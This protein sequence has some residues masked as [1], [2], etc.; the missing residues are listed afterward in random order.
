MADI[1]VTDNLGNPVDNIKVNLSRPSSILKY[2]RSELF[3]F[4]VFPDF[5]KLK[6]TTLS[7]AAPKPIQFQAT[8]QH[9]CQLGKKEAEIDVTPKAGATVRVNASSGADLFDDDPFHAPAKVSDQTGYLSAGFTGG[10][11]LGVSGSDGDLTFGFDEKSSVTVEYWKAF[12]LGSDEPTLGS[13][14]VQNLSSFVIPA[15]ISDLAGLS[16]HDVATVSGTGSLKVSGGVTFSASP[17]PLASATLPFGAGQIAVKAGATAGLS[18][19]FTISGSYQIRVRR[20]DAGTIELSFFKEKGTTFKADLS[21]S[22]GVTAGEGDGDFIG[23]LLNAISTDPVGDKNRL[24]D[25]VAANAKAFRVAIKNG[26]DHSLQASLDLALSSATDDQAAF[27]YEIQPSQ[28]T[29][30]GSL[31]VNRALKGDLT[32][33]TALEDGGPGNVLAPGITMLSSVLKQTR[34][35][36]MTLKVN[37]LGIVNLISVSELVR[38]GEIVKDDVTG[39]VTIKETVSGTRISAMT[40]PLRRSE[41]LRKA[42]FDSVLTTTCYRAGKAVSLPTFSCEQTHFALKTNTKHQIFGDYLRWFGAL[43]LLSLDERTTLLNSFSDGGTSTCVLRTFFTDAESTAMFVDA[44]GNARSQ[45]YYLN[46]GRQAMRALLDPEHQAIDRLRYQILDYPLWPQA[47]KIGASPELGTLV[48]LG[49]NDPRVVYLSGDVEVIT[50]WAAAMTDT[51][52]LVRVVRAIVESSGGA[53]LLTNSEFNKEREQLQKQLADVVKASK[54]QFSEP[55]G[56]VCLFWAGGSPVAA[57]GKV[58]VDK[59]ILERGTTDPAL[60][61]KN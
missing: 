34:D 14:L 27:Q 41:A 49:P 25:L 26:M 54:V 18:A 51:G 53:D 28:L 44:S 30:A 6:N 58:S 5:L 13:A 57:Y 9:E 29:D 43:N 42:M 23:S 16:V 17:N 2:L 55:W 56:M 50:D 15:D 3:H 19:S 46:I 36:S 45:D 37:L 21:V 60:A 4:A 35:R 32:Q 59:L 1:E 39:D 31:A 20:K 52:V 12:P 11:S 48:G 22:G 40:D 8:V 61:T 10:L 24:A 33:L 47:F 38:K 7:K